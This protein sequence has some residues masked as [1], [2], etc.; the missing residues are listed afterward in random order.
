MGLF[1][2]FIM[3]I[4]YFINRQLP[5]TMITVLKLQRLKFSGC[6]ASTR[7]S[8]SAKRAAPSKGTSAPK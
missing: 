2:F 6:T 5:D 4:G 7:R 3:Q 1:V 8:A